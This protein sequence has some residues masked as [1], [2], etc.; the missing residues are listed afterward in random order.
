MVQRLMTHRRIWRT[1]S[2]GRAEIE[3]LLVGGDVT[4]IIGADGAT[5]VSGS[6]SRRLA[7]V[8]CEEA[9]EAGGLIYL[10][11]REG[12]PFVM[13][14]RVLAEGE[15]ARL[16]AFVKARIKRRPAP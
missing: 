9:E 2:R 5:Q 7:F 1:R 3:R 15:A 11:R 14:C 16:M 10:W 8:D 13:P 12:A 6:D 4:T